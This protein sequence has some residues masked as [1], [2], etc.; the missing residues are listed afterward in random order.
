M[1]NTVQAIKRILN[2]IRVYVDKLQRGKKLSV[3]KYPCTLSVLWE[4]PT[5]SLQQTTDLTKTILSVN[6]VT[7]LTLFTAPIY[8]HLSKQAYKSSNV[9]Q[10]SKIRIYHP[11]LLYITN[12]HNLGVKM[13][14]H[15]DTWNIHK[16]SAYSTA[17]QW[18]GG[19]CNNRK[20]FTSTPKAF[21]VSW[22]GWSVK[23]SGALFA[24]V[25]YGLCAFT[26][27]RG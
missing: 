11:F 10:T 26:S 27:L 3:E 23:S 22:K 20:C 19:C 17:R 24:L 15:T 18:L 8:H 21:C 12:M 14:V 5:V 4:P 25:S 9:K 13:L 7:D 2:D 6:C 1:D 16:K